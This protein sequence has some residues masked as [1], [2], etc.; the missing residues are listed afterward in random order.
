MDTVKRNLETAQQAHIAAQAA[1]ERARLA[2]SSEIGGENPTV[3]RL[4]AELGDAEYDL[5]QTTT[6]ALSNGFVTQ[7]ALRPGMYTVPLPLRPA[8]V[9]VHTDE[10]DR[11]LAAAFQQ[12][13]LQRRFVQIYGHCVKAGM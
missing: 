11:V 8:M 13:A 10:H 2:Y 12:N 9:F 6:R 7:L 1:Q 5:A 4:R 3:A